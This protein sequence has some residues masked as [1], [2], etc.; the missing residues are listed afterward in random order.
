MASS[1]RG[2]ATPLFGKRLREAREMAGIAQ[3]KLGVLIGL[4]ESSSSA[5]ISRYETGVHEPPVRTAKQI[6]KVLKVPLA[7][8]YCDDDVL[9]AILLQAHRMSKEARRALLAS[10]QSE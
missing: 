1:T 10:M 6:A 4:D 9:A 5:R 8:L 7:F 3:D 2:D